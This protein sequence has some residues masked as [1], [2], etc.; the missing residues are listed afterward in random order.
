M[1]LP[2]PA[3]VGRRGKDLRSRAVTWFVGRVRATPNKEL[4]TFDGWRARLVVGG[5][6]RLLPLAVDRRRAARYRPCAVEWRITE[7]D[8]GASVHTLFVDDGRARVRRGVVASPD[9][10]IAMDTADF[11][12]LAAGIESGVALFMDG[13]L[14]LD[15]DPTVA[16]KLSRLFRPPRKRP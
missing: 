10:T 8:G 6:L 4:E 12:R 15:G 2:V 1:A 9:L 11:L 14:K 16:L 5:L 3:A 7:P 13:R